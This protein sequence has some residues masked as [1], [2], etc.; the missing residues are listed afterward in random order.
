MI[1]GTTAGAG[2]VIAGN[3]SDGV[4]ITGASQNF[5]QGNRIGL[6]VAGAELPNGRHGVLIDGPLTT[7]TYVSMDVPRT[8][9]PEDDITVSLVEIPSPP[10]GQVIKDVNVNLS[11]AHASVGDLTITL[12]VPADGDLPIVLADR[13]GGSGD[14]FTS[15]TF[16]DQAA[17]PIS[18]G[19]PPFTGSFRPEQMLSILNGGVFPGTWR[20]EIVDSSEE[21][22]T[23]LNWSVTITVGFPE[24]TSENL[25]GG[26]STNA[27]NVISGNVGDGVAITGGDAFGNL[28]QGNFIGTDVSGALDRGNAGAGVLIDD[29]RN[30]TIGGTISGAGNVIAFNGTPPSGDNDTGVAVESGTGNAILGN[31]IF[32]HIGL[33]IDLNH[34]GVT[35]NDE[36]MAPFDTDLGA[37]NLQNFPVITGVTAAGANTLLSGRLRSTP[38]TQFRI[39]F[40][41]N[42]VRDPSGFGEG[43]TFLGSVLT[44]ASDANGLVTFMGSFS[45]VIPAGRFLTATATD[46]ANNTS[47]FSAAVCSLIV[48]HT[49]DGGIGSLR[50]AMTCAN[51]IAN[52][53][54]TGDGIADPDP[55]SFAIPGTTVHTITPLTA[56]PSI[57]EAA[58]IDGY[59]QPGASPNTLAVGSD[60]A[61]R[62]EIDGSTVGVFSLA[63]LVVASGGGGS[64]LRG[65][66]VNRFANP[67]FVGIPGILLVSNN[68]VV[69]GNFIGTDPT[70]TLDRGNGT[71]GIVVTGDNNLIGGTTPAARNLISGNGTTGQGNPGNGIFVNSTVVLQSTGPVGTKIQGNYIGTD[72]DGLLP[73]GNS[74]SGIV[75]R[76]GIGTLIGGDDDDDGMLDGV[77]GARNLISGHDASGILMIPA[78]TAVFG[79]TVQGNFIGVDAT[80]SMALA[81]TEGVTISGD[82]I[83]DLDATIGGTAPGAGNVLSGNRFFG[84]RVFNAQTLIVQGNFVGTDATGIMAIGNGFGGIS[85]AINPNAPLDYALTI[86]GDT[87][88]A[89]NLISGNVDNFGGGGGF[90]IDAGGQT[91]GF[92]HIRRNL[93]GTQVDGVTPLP[94]TG[95]GIVLSRSA[96]VGGTNADDGNTIANNGSDGV[97]VNTF[98]Q[99]G[100][101]S[102][103]V[104]LGNSIFSNGGLGIEL[105]VD[106]LADGVPLPNDTGDG[107]TGPNNLQNY[108]VLTTAAA[109]ATSLTI[110]ATLNST[111]NSSF[112]V[113]F[114]ASVAADPSG[115]GEGQTFLGTM[116]VNTDAN[117]N[118]GPFTFMRSGDFRGQFYTA[119]AT[120]I[121]TQTQQPTET[122]EFSAAI[123][124][125][126]PV[127]ISIGDFTVTEGNTG[128]VDAV[129]AVTLSGPSAQPV[130]VA[131][132]TANNTATAGSDYNPTMGGFSF[133]PGQTS[134]TITVQVLGDTLDEVDETFFVNL[135]DPINATIADG[136][137][138]GTIVDDDQPTP[139]LT[140]NDFTVT[141]GN[142]GTVDAVFI[143]TLSAPSSQSV[144][145]AFATANGTADTTDYQPTMGTFT[146]T[147]GTFTVAPGE[148]RKSLT[149][150]IIGDTLDE[151]DETFFVNLSAPTNA[152]IADGQGVGTILDDDEQE[153]ALKIT[154]NDVT[155]TEGDQ[156]TVNAVFVVSISGPPQPVVVTFET[157]NNTADPSDYQPT[158]GVITFQPGEIGRNITIRVLGD[159]LDDPIETFFVNLTNV[160]G[161]TI[162]DGQGI[163]TILDDDVPDAPPILVTGA[164]AG[165]GPHVKV[166]NASTR[167]LLFEFMAY[168]PLFAGGVRVA[169]GDVNADGVPDVVTGAGPG[170]GPHV[171]VFDGRNGQQLPGLVGSFFAYSANFTGGVYVASGDVNGD[172][173]DDIITGADAGG[174]PHVRV[175]DG[176]TGQQLAGLIGSFFAYKSIDNA[177]VR[178][179][180]GDVNGDG[181]A[182]VITGMGPGYADDAARF[183]FNPISQPEVRVFSGLD[184]RMLRSFL[185]FEPGYRGG[186]HLAVGHFDGD[187][188]A[189]IIVS[190]ANGDGRTDLAF[191]RSHIDPFRRPEVTVFR[192]QDGMPPARV[193][194]FQAYAGF[195]G[196]VRVAIL[197]ELFKEFDDDTFDDDYFGAGLITGAGPT[198][199]PHVKIFSDDPPDL[200]DEFFAYGP[201]FTGGIFVAAGSPRAED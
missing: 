50:E 179:A 150:R 125:L 82:F 99:P 30:N 154:I 81:N 61:L 72:A 188:R 148:T 119:T 145:V 34:N 63:G 144:T 177:G 42:E 56:L 1:G 147:P 185:P 7:T 164:D 13:R 12:I 166:F 35:L 59:T 146:F 127:T 153:E 11:L 36:S 143:I 97:V 65:L 95:H 122:S 191:N 105:A 74:D 87:D 118:A 183:G 43:Q 140:I 172:G 53:D 111:P 132:N 149:V 80:G 170:G 133:E 47:E 195:G 24:P 161:A 104:I 115:F 200:L 108:P 96:I 189:E 94:N 5:V 90:G 138:V 135:V 190:K 49:G 109:T 27:R 159:T 41:V 3:E 21:T 120:R 17:T 26:T 79:V 83:P 84:L 163:G 68:N 9:S 110:E 193:A 23:I 91:T 168:N 157:A 184:G 54:R 71:H 181:R 93:I 102:G 156:G 37:N 70:G 171:R 98:N 45:G 100:A 167:E 116:N 198:G 128:T 178:V 6:N 196:S 10:V 199:G 76:T 165:G 69:E 48:T 155:V 25:V 112:R 137:G 131:F 40:F 73:L 117:G 31:N 182:D 77:V 32:S 64:T 113:E 141:E 169:V 180:A 103:M 39:E 60:A 28:V 19:T 173:A 187:L 158:M 44:A 52:F 85:L 176:R 101:T 142:A 55:I 174:G 130:F 33:G 88:A 78:D 134:R 8:I 38:N 29:V 2:N 139:T 114:F 201:N 124:A 126:Q 75:V 86:G 57:N 123:Q 92:L 58:I 15:T 151:P 46:P 18:T 175:F 160:T 62:I 20:L 136:Q 121:D 162:E 197:D 194:G 89:R 14:N 192:H 107:D 152:T 4:R 51:A 129:F 186:V 16:D 67:R 22:G 106:F 66:V